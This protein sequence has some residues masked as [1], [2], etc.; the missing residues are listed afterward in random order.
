MGARAFSEFIRQ[1]GIELSLKPDGLS[2]KDVDRLVDVI[3]SSE[4]TPM[5]ENNCYSASDS[6]IRKFA[7]QLLSR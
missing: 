3:Y 5:R 7:R 1:S 2:H 4:N 6:D